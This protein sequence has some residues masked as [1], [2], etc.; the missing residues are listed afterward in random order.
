MTLKVEGGQDRLIPTEDGPSPPEP[1]TIGRRA[2][3]P[4]KSR[5][6][7]YRTPM[8]KTVRT[9]DTDT[10]NICNPETLVDLSYLFMLPLLNAEKRLDNQVLG[11]VKTGAGDEELTNK[12]LLDTGATNYSFMSV[13]FVK[14]VI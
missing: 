12:V 9:I 10:Y 7:P 14:N 1:S 13:D 11:V 2:A 4:E 5:N 6:S 3:E 8:K